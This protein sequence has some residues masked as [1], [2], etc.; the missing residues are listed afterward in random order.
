[1][2]WLISALAIGVL[3]SAET[4]P[5]G[6]DV[7]HVGVRPFVATGVAVRWLDSEADHRSS[8]AYR[9]GVRLQ[10][11]SNDLLS[12]GGEAS[13]FHIDEVPTGNFSHDY[14]CP[15]LVVEHAFRGPIPLVLAAWSLAHIGA[16]SGTE[17]GFALGYGLGWQPKIDPGFT[18]FLGLRS[19]TIGM[20]GWT[21]FYA[22]EGGVRWMW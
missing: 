11:W 14:V 1:M 3:A 2:R 19:E 17:D 16:Q 9:A 8:F 12:V 6:I 21:S 13:W 22:L 7:A 18:P 15:G 4:E 20:G 10:L 5:S